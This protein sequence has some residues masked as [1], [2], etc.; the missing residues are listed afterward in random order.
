[1]ISVIIPARNEVQTI[2]AVV[3]FVRSDPRVTQVVVIDDG[4]IDGTVEAARLAGA[5]TIS[6]S[7][8]GKGASMEDGVRSASEETLL[9]LDGDLTDLAPDLVDRMVAP[10]LA[11]EADMVKARFVRQAGRV[12]V[13]TAR[14]LLSAFFPE[15]DQYEQPLGGI[16][17]ARRRV[18]ERLTFEND[19][20]VDVAL[21]ID[22]VMSGL[23][24][25]QV[26]I[27]S[28]EHR[29]QT[30][31]R[32][33][34]MALQVSR[35]ILDRAA[36]YRRLGASRVREAAERERRHQATRPIPSE[37]QGKCAGLVLFD[38]DG[39][40]VDERF[41][42]LLA[43]ET[44]RSRGLAAYLDRAELAP[45]ERTRGIGRLFRGVRQQTFQDVAKRMVLSPGAVETVVQLR[46]LGWRVGVITDS[47]FVAADV[48]R[49]RVFADFCLA[50]LLHFRDG[51]ATGDVALNP[52]MSCGL[53]CPE[54]V[55]CKRNALGQL[56]D[57]LRLTLDRVI[58]VGDSD[59]DVCLLR[60]AGCGIAFRPKS[61]L[62]RGAAAHVVEDTLTRV[63]EIVG[64]LGLNLSAASAG[65]SRPGRSSRAWWARG[66]R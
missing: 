17:A 65:D 14:P 56:L 66:G 26:D 2:R 48:V 34:D 11:G 47:F 4:S 50:H 24:V 35:T 22:A 59:N 8:L 42:E 19:Y 1:M 37:E 63:I 64:G 38:M 30:L 45:E 10:L 18:L 29:S 25:V 57:R 16:I 40:L 21:L 32:L 58:A 27:G 28:I 39:T 6:S 15:L 54:H 53:G 49:R 41:V 52:E 55:L 60:A 61:E 62:A 5:T 3:E 7:L 51:R 20:G 9:F 12:T 13:L 36:R 44:G 33:G 31:D 46:Q 23:R 43:R